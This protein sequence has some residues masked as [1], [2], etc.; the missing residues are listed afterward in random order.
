M[1]KKGQFL[2]EAT[3]AIALVAIVIIG[4]FQGLTLGIMGTY[5]DSQ[6]NTALHLAQSQME[7]I[8]LQ[9]FNDEIETLCYCSKCDGDDNECYDLV[10][11]PESWDCDNPNIDIEVE[12]T[13]DPF[14]Y[15][16]PGLQ[17]ITVTVS[18][19]G[20][21]VELEGYKTKR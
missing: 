16:T 9:T 7:Y 14:G 12:V 17:L 4:I 5:R 10:E 15:G 8:K 20:G 21:S 6:H 11:L 2:I 1:K 19:D 18:Y 13:D 3:I